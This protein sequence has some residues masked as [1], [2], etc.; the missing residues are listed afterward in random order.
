MCCCI[1]S[2]QCINPWWLSQPECGRAELCLGAGME[3]SPGELCQALWGAHWARAW[4]GKRTCSCCW[5]NEREFQFLLSPDWILT[6]EMQLNF[7]PVLKSSLKNMVA[8]YQRRQSAW[9]DVCCTG[10]LSW[11]ISYSWNLIR[12]YAVFPKKLFKSE[13]AVIK[14]IKQL[15]HTPKLQSNKWV[16]EISSLR[17]TPGH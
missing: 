1:Y 13:I 8:R 6:Y 3:L 17:R 12:R 11:E 14:K 9:E 2:I 7:L 5:G 4:L 10:Y 15:K 16:N